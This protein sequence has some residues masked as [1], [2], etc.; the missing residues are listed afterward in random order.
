MGKKGGRKECRKGERE[1]GRKRE[2]WSRRG[3]EE[4]IKGEGGERDR[5]RKYCG[6]SYLPNFSA[7]K[8]RRARS[9]VEGAI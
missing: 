9:S 3:K 4:R 8:Y 6:Y 7:Q 5:G 1:G 2:G